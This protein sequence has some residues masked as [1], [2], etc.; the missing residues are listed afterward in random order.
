MAL[1]A[2]ILCLVALPVAP[3]FLMRSFPPCA[4]AALYL[5]LASLFLSIC[6]RLLLLFSEVQIAFEDAMRDIAENTNVPTVV[7]CDRS[8]QDSAAYVTEE[9]YKEILEDNEWTRGQ[10][11]ARANC[12]VH[13]I[14]AADG[15]S[16]LLLF[17]LH[18]LFSLFNEQCQVQEDVL[19]ILA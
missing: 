16:C 18:V 2:V 10:L 4:Y 12:V 6:G 13:L 3:R 1:P 15:L 19:G 9:Q 11:I 14:T 8:A 5:F 7:L 17:L